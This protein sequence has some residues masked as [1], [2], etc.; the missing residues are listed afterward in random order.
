MKR[1]FHCFVLVC[2]AFVYST[3]L[4][5]GFAT[6]FSEHIFKCRTCVHFFG[7]VIISLLNS[8][9]KILNLGFLLSSHWLFEHRRIC[10][11]AVTTVLLTI[12]CSSQELESVHEDVQAMSTCCEEMTNRLKVLAV[13]DLSCLTVISKFFV[14]YNYLLKLNSWQT[15][16]IV[17]IYIPVIVGENV[18]ELTFKPVYVFSHRLRRSKLKIS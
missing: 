10:C 11:S 3:D 6:C 5:W 15:I 7:W 16:S 18:F 1:L 4:Y 13:N 12:S 9:T 14:C 17:W 8:S 2:I